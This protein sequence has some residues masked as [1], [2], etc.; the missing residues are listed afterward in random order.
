MKGWGFYE[1]DSKYNADHMRPIE[2]AKAVF[3]GILFYQRP[4]KCKMLRG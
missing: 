3:Y 4:K 1:K 2:G